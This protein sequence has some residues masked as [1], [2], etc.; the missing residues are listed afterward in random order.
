MKTTLSLLRLTSLVL[1]VALT[2]CSKKT[3]DVLPGG[4][5]DPLLE[6]S[7]RLVSLKFTVKNKGENP[8]SATQNTN[9][10]GPT[11]EYRADGT[12]AN[13]NGQASGRYTSEAGKFYL[14][15]DAQKGVLTF[16]IQSLSATDFSYGAND[17]QTYIALARS[18]GATEPAAADVAKVEQFAFSL[19][20]TKSAA[21]GPTKK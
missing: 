7:W 5:H 1:L 3:D 17:I 4:T 20:L 10:T 11:V 19:N 21:T 15:N 9:A 13:T 2:A 8:Q 18:L 6:G 12:W 16:D 14:T